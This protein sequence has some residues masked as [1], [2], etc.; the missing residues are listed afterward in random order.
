MFSRQVRLN[1]LAVA[2]I[3]CYSQLINKIYYGSSVELHAL[4]MQGALYRIAA[5]VA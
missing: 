3:A 5:A 1:T 4:V 2:N